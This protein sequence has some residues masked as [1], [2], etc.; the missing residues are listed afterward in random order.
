MIKG[1][2]MSGSA[3]GFSDE[4]TY[5]NTAIQYEITEGG[6]VQL[7]VEDCAKALGVTQERK[8]KDGI[9]V[10]VRWERVYS[11][12]VS[13][14]KIPSSGDFTKL[15][16]TKK[17]EVRNKLKQLTVSESELYLWSFVVQSEQAKNFRTWVAE[18][19]LPS[20]REHG[21]YINGMEN[22]TPEEVK[23]AADQRV[24]RFILRKF[25]I[26]VR[27]KLTDAIKQ[28]IN[29]PSHE[30]YKYAIYTNLLYNV[31]FGMDCQEYK[32]KLGLT[33]K[34]SLRD[35]IRDSDGYEKLT[36]LAEA[37]EFMGNLIRSGITDLKMLKNM[38]TTWHES[39]FGVIVAK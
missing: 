13:I 34:D 18:T 15:S 16:K 22:M 23:Q 37:E 1:K 21:I 39:K 33:K 29:P 4:F 38:M 7:Y 26:T 10:N 19:V 6:K 8:V 28:V 32:D 11:H 3:I 14:E 35:T 17:Q 31:M 24:E 36:D 9:N 20:L 2:E 27:K 12:L 30:S 25:G 5:N